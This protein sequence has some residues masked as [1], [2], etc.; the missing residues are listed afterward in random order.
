MTN[1]SLSFGIQPTNLSF[2]YRGSLKTMLPCFLGA[3]AGEIVLSQ[4]IMAYFLKAAKRAEL[5]LDM[6][7][8]LFY[9]Y[10]FYDVPAAYF[11]VVYVSHMLLVYSRRRPGS[12]LVL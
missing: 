3:L 4:R 5:L 7:L 1:L 9:F 6:F 10:G 8:L 12:G 11:G 2:G